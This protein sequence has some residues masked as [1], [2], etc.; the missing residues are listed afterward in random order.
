MTFKEAEDRYFEDL[1]NIRRQ[2]TTQCNRILDDLGLYDVD[3]IRI[4]DGK[5]GRLKPYWC[6][7]DRLYISFFPYIESNHQL[8]YKPSDTV[9]GDIDWLKEHFQKVE[10]TL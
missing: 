3:V 2:F 10:I 4:Q 7:N 5:I 8:S 6:S 9:C 1:S